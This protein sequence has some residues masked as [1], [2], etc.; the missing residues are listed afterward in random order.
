[1][2]CTRGSP[3]AAP[4]HFE[5]RHEGILRFF[6]ADALGRAEQAELLRAIRAEHERVRDQLR[7]EIK[8]HAAEA[9][10]AGEKEFPL[11]TVEFGIAY[12]EFL[13]GW[14]ERLER[15]IEEPAK[16]KTRR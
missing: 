2:P 16:T 6:F 5:L 3:P 10:A 4:L 7:D 14:C 9:A 13:M 12:Q 1:M 11:R 8:P 15:E